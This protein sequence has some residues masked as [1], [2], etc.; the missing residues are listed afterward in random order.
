VACGRRWGKTTLGLVMA[1]NAVLEG[2]RVWWVAP[3]Y[4]LA[5]HPWHTFKRRFAS[6]WDQKTEYQRHIDLPNGGSITVKTADNPDGL[7]G[8]GVDFVVV[9]EA[10]FIPG[11]TWQG[12]IRPAL[13]DRSGGALLISTPRGRNW[14]FHAYQRGL[15]PAVADWR[16]WHH[17]TSSNPAISPQDLAEAR[18][19]LPESIYR[20]EYEAQFLEDGGMVFR[21]I[22]QAAAAPFA[23]VPQPG[24]TYVMG[25]D[26]ARYEDFTALV[27]IDSTEKAVVAVDRFSGDTWGMQ[28]VRIVALAKKWSV[29]DVLAESNAM[30]EPNIEALYRDGLPIRSFRTT[31][32]SKPPLI[33]GLVAAIEN[34]DLQLLPDPVLLAELEGYTYRTS[35]LGHTV[36]EAPPGS[37]DDTVIAL[38]LAWSA[39]SRPRLAFGILEA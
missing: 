20:Q 8:V 15:D 34:G 33:E 12:C 27:V 25:V 5:Y 9:D 16:S 38:A 4:L 10:A 31:A 13:S 36:Y 17:P 32:A 26:F 37:H 24:H 22:R 18:A 35:R 14:F 6:S 3:T 1:V 28:R 39:A 29:W 2:R 23:A 7:R 30:G 11:E 21:R 19:A